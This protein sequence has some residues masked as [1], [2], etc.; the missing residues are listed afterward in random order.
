MTKQEKIGK[1][2]YLKCLK[3]IR[4]DPCVNI[5]ENPVYN[6]PIFMI[7]AV[8]KGGYRIMQTNGRL[9]SM[10]EVKSKDITIL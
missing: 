2:C 3:L 10:L 8:V 6:L 1:E 4:T 9:G 7:V 5:R